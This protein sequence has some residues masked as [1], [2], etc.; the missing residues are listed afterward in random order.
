LLV[1]ASL[2]SNAC[3]AHAL[4]IDSV[5]KNGAVL[6]VPPQ[7]VELRFNVRIERALARASLRTG[8][9]AP[10]ALSPLRA[11]PAQSERLIIPL[12]PVGAG[13]QEVHYKVLAAD[14]HAT[15]GV[16][17]FRVQP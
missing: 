4:V 14:G 11:G 9:A 2:I 7:Q 1:A 6:R 5:P 13:E 10:S 17:R 16:L 8:N 3:L 15:E 12:P